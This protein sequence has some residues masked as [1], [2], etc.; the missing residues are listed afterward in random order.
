MKCWFCLFALL[1]ANCYGGVVVSN[2]NSSNYF[3]VRFE[4]SEDTPIKV[5]GV[6]L[7]NQNDEFWVDKNNPVFESEL[8]AFDVPFNMHD[9][10]AYTDFKEPSNV[11]T[12]GEGKNPRTFSYFGDAPT[13]VVSTYA[14]MINSVP[15]PS[16]IMLGLIGMVWL[17]RRK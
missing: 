11:I 1:C 13:A 16:T 10:S 9:L 14:S 8:V 3:A 7:L 12:V 2:P 5:D 17:V 15:E 4:V 6:Q